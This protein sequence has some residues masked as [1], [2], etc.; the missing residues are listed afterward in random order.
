MISLLNYIEERFGPDERE[1]WAQ[2]NIGKGF[3]GRHHN[4]QP[5]R[6]C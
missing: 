3:Y 2:H 5:L 4:G 1:S 6:S